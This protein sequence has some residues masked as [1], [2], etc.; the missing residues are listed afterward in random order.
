MFFYIFLRKVFK[1]IM[2]V[3]IKQC[4]QSQISQKNTSIIFVKNVT[5]LRVINLI[6]KNTV[7]R[8][9]IKMRLWQ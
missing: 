4:R 9:S 2:F 6:T 5:I 8:S 7:R 3:N 1:N